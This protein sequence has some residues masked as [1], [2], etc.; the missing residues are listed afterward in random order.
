M[1]FLLSFTSNQIFLYL[2]LFLSVFFD[3]IIF[4]SLFFIWEIFIISGWYLSFEYLNIFLT[5]FILVLA[6]SFWDNVNYFIWK[7]YWRKIFEKNGKIFNEKQLKRWEKL[8]KKFWLKIVFLSRII[9]PFYWIV[10][11]ICGTFWLD[12]KRFFIFNFLW[13]CFWVFHFM[14]YWYFFAAWFAYFWNSIFINI[15]LFIVFFYLLFLF[16]YRSKTFF[17]D[18]KYFF[19]IILFLKYLFS[20]FFIFLFILSYYYFFLYP[21]DAKFYDNT[22]KI[23]NIELF[24]KNIEKKI[25]SDK[26]IKTNSNPINIAIVTDKDIDFLMQKIWWEKNL[27]FS[28][29]EIDFFKFFSL[30]KSKTPPISDYYHNSFNQNYQYQDISNSNKSRNHIRF[31]Q[32]WKDNSWKNIFI[33]SVSQDNNFW[34]MINNWLPIIGHSIEKNIDFSRNYFINLLKKNFENITLKKID[35]SDFSKKNYFTDWDIYF[36]NI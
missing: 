34:I 7:K 19:I 20:Y 9:F 16:I 4:S 31:W 28:S 27:S 12:Y 5:Y 32:V 24:L 15:L 30:L 6:A 26:I 13:A 18:K 8:I 33:W 14:A 29:W 25:Y 11:T 10:P 1:D 21:K 17:K 36:I 23:E 22:Q 2:I 35:F 3:S